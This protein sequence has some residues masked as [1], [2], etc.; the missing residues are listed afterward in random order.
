MKTGLIYHNLKIFYFYYSG[1]R[2]NGYPTTEWNCCNPTTQCGVG[3]GD[4]DTD[5]DCLG[6]LICGSSRDSSN[7]CK[8]DFSNQRSFWTESADCCTE[9]GQVYYQHSILLKLKDI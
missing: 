2:C 3:E 5:D 1:P 6:D 9:P 8:N 7:N 4:C